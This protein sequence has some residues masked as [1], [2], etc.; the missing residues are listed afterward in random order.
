MNADDLADEGGKNTRDY[1]GV[2][3]VPIPARTPE[4]RQSLPPI[5]VHVREARKRGREK[6]KKGRPL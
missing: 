4:E 2:D 1:Q 5:G 6:K 3:Y